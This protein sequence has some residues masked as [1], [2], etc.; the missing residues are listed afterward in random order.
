VADRLAIQNYII[1]LVRDRFFP[2]VAYDTTT[3]EAKLVGGEGI[4]PSTCV[5]N[6]I[7][8]GFAKDEKYGR[9]EALKR[10][11]WVFD[12]IIKFGAEVSLEEFEQSLCNP[13]PRIPSDKSIFIRGCAI[14]LAQSFVQHPVI[15]NA[16]TGTEARL[17]F[18]VELNRN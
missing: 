4:K 8:S 6:E 18:E 15:N 3:G 17:V 9:V 12:L 16:P 5:S 1:G 13:V 14:R 7:E 10:T 2:R 11:R